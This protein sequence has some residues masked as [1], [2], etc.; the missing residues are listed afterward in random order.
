M[1]DQLFS[2]SFC[3]VELVE[4]KVGGVLDE[5][6]QPDQRHP[7]A[8]EFHGERVCDAVEAVPGGEGTG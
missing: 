5:S 8:C 1:D 4:V 7:L 3:T 2:F 6:G